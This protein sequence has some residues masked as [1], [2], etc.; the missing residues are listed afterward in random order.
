ME[1]TETSLMTEIEELIHLLHKTP[2]GEV[3]NKETLRNR[4]ESA[5]DEL[6]ELREGKK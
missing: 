2:E 3:T 1:K 4:L 6:T 5:V